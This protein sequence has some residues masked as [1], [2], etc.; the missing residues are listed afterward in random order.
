METNNFEM[1]KALCMQSES[2]ILIADTSFNILWNNG[3]MDAAGLDAIRRSKPLFKGLLSGVSDT[4]VKR[5]S[6]HISFSGYPLGAGGVT[7]MKSG[8]YILCFATPGMDE[9]ALE[10]LYLNSVDRFTDIVRTAVERLSLNTQA[11]ERLIDSDDPELEE[12]FEGIRRGAYRILKATYGAALIASYAAGTI[13]AVKRP[14]DV[15]ELVEKLCEGVT[16]VCDKHIPLFFSLPEQAVTTLLDI[17]LAE[18]ALLAVISNSL[19]YTRD[20]NA[21][22]IKVSESERMIIITVKDRGQ[23]IK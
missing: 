5:G 6:A 16:A 22:E 11:A 2:Q 3:R 20:G 17:K 10:P 12:T 19:T 13:S 9:S 7:F 1:L 8:E 18:R 4:L 14:C 21:I 23:G 15:C